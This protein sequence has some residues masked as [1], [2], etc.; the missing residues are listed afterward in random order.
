MILEFSKYHGAGN[1][2]VLIDNRD[3]RF[4]LT[5]GQIRNLCDRHLGIGGD[6]LMLLGVS[7]SYDFSM[8][9]Y[10]SDGNESTM[11]GNGGRC[12]TAFARQLGF[13]KNYFVFDAIDGIHESKLEEIHDHVF[14]NLRMIDVDISSLAKENLF[15]NTGSPH[16]IEYVGDL[17]SIDVVAIGRRIRNSEKYKASNGT[18]VNFV[19]DCGSHIRIRTYE[20]GV[21]NETL[22]CGTG[23][24]AA[25]IAKGLSSGQNSVTVKALGGDLKVSFEIQDGFARNVWLYGPAKFVFKGLIEI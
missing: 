25:A 17:D 13:N 3:S 21:E 8:R 16:H 20:R 2:F 4:Q 1:D 24:T 14:V 22:A 10:N 15:L 7:D 19:H 23:A 9:Y 12:I 11:C 5:Q 6:G 18:N